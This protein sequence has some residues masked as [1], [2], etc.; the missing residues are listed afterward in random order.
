[1]VCRELEGKCSAGSKR[2]GSV[3]DRQSMGERR[4]PSHS[5]RKKA[6]YPTSAIYILG[7]RPPPSPENPDSSRC[8]PLCDRDPFLPPAGLFS[9]CLVK[10][11]EF[12]SA[13]PRPQ[14][15][16]DWST[17]GVALKTLEEGGT[18]QWLRPC[19]LRTCTGAGEGGGTCV[20]G[21]N[22]F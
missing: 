13:D 12:L 10:G 16:G 21:R 20:C 19:G 15:G 5:Y 7:N 17:K 14:E 3:D 22:N 2:W 6:G 8:G 9:W 4:T 11:G 18:T 1:M